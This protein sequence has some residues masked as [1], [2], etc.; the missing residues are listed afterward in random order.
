VLF[1]GALL[2][3]FADLLLRPAAARSVLVEQR[4]PAPRPQVPSD[5]AAWSTFPQRFEAWHN[6]V[7]GQRDRLIR[8]HNAL[9]I[10]GFGVSPSS[11]ILVGREHWIFTT[12]ER[13]IEMWRGLAPFTEKE[14]AAWKRALESRRAWLHER[15]IA[16]LFV[17]APSKAEIYPEFMPQGLNRV[18]PNR[19]DQLIEYLR[20]HSDLE[21]LD[22]RP[23]VMAEKR[24]DESGCYTF[25]PLGIH[26]NIRGGFAAYRAIVEALA[27]PL[28]LPAPERREAVVWRE[29]DE[30]GD[31]WAERLYLAD[32]LRQRNWE[33]EFPSE[34]LR[35]EPVRDRSQRM[36]WCDQA[37]T[38]LP[39]ALV[40]HDSFAEI[41]YDLL[42]R[43]FSRTLFVWKPD[44]DPALVESERPDVVIQIFGDRALLSQA[45]RGMGGQ[46]SDAARELFEASNRVLLTFD[47]RTNRPPVEAQGDAA[48][49]EHASEAALA[50]QISS[51]RGL[52]LLPEFRPPEEHNPVLRLDVTSPAQTE[53]QI[54]YQTH[55]A[56]SYK[57]TRQYKLAL[58]AGRNELYLEVLDPD[59]TGRLLVRPG[60][61]AGRYLLHALEVRAVRR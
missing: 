58:A 19:T 60:L 14:L 17:L 38:S 4:R 48:L 15:G 21:L 30:Q 37:G 61:V 34:P 31:S 32:V 39:R 22:L 16:F 33:V 40:F 9:K 13:S 2:A 57:P 6:D 52:L 43:R 41:L 5:L 54:F 11:R 44:I 28:D 49:A 55:E 24:F 1:L 3:P 45:P 23:V 35:L 59:F 51:E 20:E 29:I 8:W 47:S 50:V 12:S 7:F 25:F 27:E 46:D 26:W 10:L 53:L 42:P 36:V 18:G 56:P